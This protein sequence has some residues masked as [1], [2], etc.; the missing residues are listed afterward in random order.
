MGQ[1][2]MLLEKKAHGWSPEPSTVVGGTSDV[3]H[4]LESLLGS[5]LDSSMV[6]FA[7]A[8]THNVSCRHTHVEVRR[9]Q[10]CVNC[11][12]KQ[13]PGMPCVDV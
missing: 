10:R 12:I 8:H 5:I 13:N 7:R 2:Q 6:S 4:L 1:E 11:H 9:L 3:S